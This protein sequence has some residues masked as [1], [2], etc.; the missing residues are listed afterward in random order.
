MSRYTET[1][2]RGIGS[3]IGDS[4]KGVI[5]G[6][7]LFLASFFLLYWNEGRENLA[8][9]AETA[10]GV[11]LAEIAT[12][13][14]N[15][16][17]SLTDDFATDTL[18]GDDFLKA[19]PRFGLD[20][21]VE[22]YLWQETQNQESDVELGGTETRRTAYTYRKEWTSFY[23]DSSNFRVPEGHTNPRIPLDSTMQKAIVGTVGPLTFNPELFDLPAGN[24]VTLTAENVIEKDGYTRNNS[25]YLFKGKGTMQIPEI[26]DVRISYREVK[27]PLNYATI[28]G[29][30][31]TDRQ[32]INPFA[33]DKFTIGRIFKGDR[34]NAISKLQTEHDRTTWLLRLAGFGMM[35][36]GLLLLVG[37]IVTL[38]DI[39]PILGSLGRGLIGVIAFVVAFV[40]SAL[41]IIVSA[42]VHN[43]F[44]LIITIVVAI[45]LALFYFRRKAKSRKR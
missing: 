28:F 30:I 35:F 1:T 19:E 33:T 37:P 23:I 20:R 15:T 18:L 5:V 21:K 38:L 17:I 9:V 27:T 26:G 31:D 16:F 24:I 10:V 44:A 32:M 13:A 25:A 11:N 41:T 36:F 3:R 34:Q 42:I 29:L 8:E 22:A 14:D 40:L 6:L 4:I 39:L 2:R 45:A 43:I 7:V 12:T